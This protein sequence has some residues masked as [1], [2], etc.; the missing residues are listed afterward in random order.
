MN[1]ATQSTRLTQDQQGGFRENGYCFPIRVL[2]DAETD[3][4]RRQFDRFYAHHKERLDALPP[5]K[6]SAIYAHTHISLHWVYRIASHPNVLD[7]VESLLG[8]NLLIWDS[9]WF[10]KRPGD[11]KFIS[12]HQDATYWCLHPPTAITA[13]IALSDSVLMNGCMRVIPGS[14]L[15][16]LPHRD[17]YGADNALSRGQEIEVEVNENEAVDVALQPGQMSLHDIS[18]V[19]GSKANASD[20]PRIGIA[21]RY[22]TP[23]VVQDGNVRQFAMLVR[24]TDEFHHYDLIDPPDSDDPETNARQVESLARMHRNILGA[25]V[26]KDKN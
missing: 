6:Q 18:I 15:R 23:E 4:F 22:I 19:H 10:I 13:W 14:H 11:A 24:G 20:R 8:P 9:V 26:K 1:D 3:E 16:H 2:Q 5:N 7:A 17:T 25:N 12:W 21:V